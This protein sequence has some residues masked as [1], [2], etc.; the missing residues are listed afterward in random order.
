MRMK[1]IDVMPAIFELNNYF[2]NK[3]MAE[4]VNINNQLVWFLEQFKPAV[5]KIS[6]IAAPASDCKGTNLLPL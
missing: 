1:N 4:I 3:N 6:K 5:S 2:I